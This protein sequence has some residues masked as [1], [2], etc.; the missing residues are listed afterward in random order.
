EL[1]QLVADPIE[2]SLLLAPLEQRVG[3]HAGNLLH[4]NNS[5]DILVCDSGVAGLGRQPGGRST[6]PTRDFVASP[7]EVIRVPR[8][9]F[10]RGWR[11]PPRRGPHRS[12]AC[13]PRSR[14]SCGSPSPWRARSGPPPPCGSARASGASPPRCLGERPPR[15]HRASPCPPWPP[16]PRRP[17]RPSGPW[18]RSRP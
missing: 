15:A 8:S 9:F 10:R 14:A 7:D 3:V 12:T 2:L 17:P 1:G 5:V 16:P 18:P 13:G 6:H 4:Q 11:S